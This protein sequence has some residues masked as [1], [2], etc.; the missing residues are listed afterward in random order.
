MLLFNYE[1]KMKNSKEY[2]EFVEYLDGREYFS[3]I[4]RDYEDLILVCNEFL[5]LTTSINVTFTR[6]T[7]KAYCYA[8]LGKSNEAQGILASLI[9]YKIYLSELDKTLFNEIFNLISCNDL[10][11]FTEESSLKVKELLK[12]EELEEKFREIVFDYTDYFN[13][14]E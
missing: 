10:K 11:S 1:L 14:T 9:Q 8:R 5:K 4:K 12:S 2:K 6:T 13:L 7:Q 3:R